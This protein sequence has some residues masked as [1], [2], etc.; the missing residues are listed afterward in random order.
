MGRLL[1]SRLSL[2]FLLVVTFGIGVLLQ[3]AP[4][5][6]QGAP[7]AKPAPNMSGCPGKPMDTQYVG[8]SEARPVERAVANGKPL[9]GRYWAPGAHSYWH[10]HPGGQF[11]LVME[12]K[13][14]VQ[15]RGE[16]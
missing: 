12:G 8:E 5:D 2:L 16:R 15:K 3:P 7:T 10:C 4:A 11:M 1:R 13:G 14:R 9:G 6:G